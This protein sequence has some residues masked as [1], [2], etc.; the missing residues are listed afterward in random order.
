MNY[1]RRFRIN[2]SI[3]LVVVFI[4]LGLICIVASRNITN[5][6]NI[7]YLDE[8]ELVPLDTAKRVNDTLLT[9]LRYVE[10]DSLLTSSCYAF[11]NYFDRDS[12]VYVDTVKNI[13]IEIDGENFIIWVDKE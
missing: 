2:I 4:V 7:L 1:W 5:N 9:T 13:I 11:G 3:Y 8:G 6:D 10:N 12:C